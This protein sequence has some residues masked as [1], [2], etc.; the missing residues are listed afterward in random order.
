MRR[1]LLGIPLLLAAPAF[2]QIESHTVT[3]SATRSLVLQ[4]DQ[5]VLQ[6]TVSSN[7]SATLDQIVGALSGLGITDANLTGTYNSNP[8]TLTWNFSFTAPLANLTATIGSITKIEQ[9][10]A[11]NNSGLTLTFYI[12]GTQVSQQLQQAQTCPNSDLISDA[13]AQAQKLAS[14]AGMSLGPILRLSNAPRSQPAEP[15]LVAENA[16]LTGVV[17]AYSFNEILL[18]PLPSPVTCSLSVQFQLLP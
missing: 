18:T 14:A 9:T 2:G 1:L 7:P 6:L 11:Q 10:I 12:G 3:I 5:I 15:A 16:T 4:P 13:T 8:P 17:G